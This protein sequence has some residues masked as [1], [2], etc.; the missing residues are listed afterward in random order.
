MT[1]TE[2]CVVKAQWSVNKL[3]LFKLF[4]SSVLNTG[5]HLS[6]YLFTLFILSQKR[7]LFMK[8]N[9]K[10]HI[11]AV[12]VCIHVHTVVFTLSYFRCLKLW[13][14]HYSNLL[15]KGL[16]MAQA[17]CWLAFCIFSLKSYAICKTHL[18]L[19]HLYSQ[20]LQLS[21]SLCSL[22]FFLFWEGPYFSKQIPC[23]SFT[24]SCSCCVTTVVFIN[25]MSFMW[26]QDVWSTIGAWL[27]YFT[28]IVKVWTSEQV[29]Q[30]I[31]RMWE[32][33]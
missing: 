6:I 20:M 22:I 14:C 17:L 32:K 31:L 8:G 23:S 5:S 3:C 21:K 16:F 13:R 25:Y 26:N 7:I 18:T 9:V 4:S 27:T 2:K 19:P 11:P 24:V 33:K 29:L 28:S 10:T 1:D 12:C 30:S 15:K